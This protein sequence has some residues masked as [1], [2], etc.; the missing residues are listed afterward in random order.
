MTKFFCD[1]CG[2][3]VPRDENSFYFDLKDLRVRV[4]FEAVSRF[5]K[6]GRDFKVPTCCVACLRIIVL[7]GV[8]Q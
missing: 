2:N 4:M 5:T 3:E 7:E 1:L 6:A 8:K